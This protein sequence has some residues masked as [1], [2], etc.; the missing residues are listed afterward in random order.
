VTLRCLAASI[1]ISQVAAQVT[2]SVY[3]HLVK[4]TQ[5][6]QTDQRQQLLSKT[7]EHMLDLADP[8]SPG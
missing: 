8:F 4:T 6:V 2:Q 5:R 1:M 7:S 3:S